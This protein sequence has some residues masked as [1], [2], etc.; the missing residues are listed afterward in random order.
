MTR[1]IFVRVG[2]IFLIIVAA[3]FVARYFIMQ[4]LSCVPVCISVNL[5]G[6]DMRGIDLS[7]VN[8]TEANLRSSDFTGANLRGS[9]FSGAKLSNAVLTKANLRG[10]A[11]IGAD[12]RGADLRGAILNGADLSGAVLDGADLTQLD[13][14]ET[15]LGGVSLAGAKLVEANLSGVNLPGIN[16][17]NADLNGANLTK[18]NLSGTSLSRANLS[19]AILVGTDIA[20]SWINLANLTGADLSGADLSGSSLIGTNLASARLA[21][22]RL[23][24]ANLVGAFFLGTDLRSASLQGIRLVVSEMQTQDYTDPE[25]ANLNELQRRT[26]IVDANLRGVQYNSQTQWPSG[27]L[28]LLAGLLGQEFAEAVAAQQVAEPTPEPTPVPEEEATAA[29]V[30]IVGQPQEETPDISFA[31]SG[32]GAPVTK[33]LYALF[34]SQ[35]YTNT[36]GFRDV[37]TNNAIALLCTSAEVDAILL[38]RRL[39]ASE[40][41]ACTTA[42]H[43]LI[44]LEVGAAVLVFIVDPT[45]AF[46]TDITTAEIPLLL[47]AEKWVQVRP[48]WPDAPIMRFL[49]S[50]G[51]GALSLLKERFF[52]ESETDPLATAP[53]TIFNPN[54]IQLVQAIATTPNS[55]G[56]FSLDNF[57]QNAEI[58][59]LV[60]VDGVTPNTTTVTSGVYSLTQPLMF[61][62]DLARVE[63]KPEAGY[64]LWF[65]LDTI[66]TLLERAGFVLARPEVMDLNRESLSPIP[67]LPS[68]PAAEDTTGEA[69]PTPEVGGPESTPT[70]E[71]QREGGGS[72]AVLPTPTI[73]ASSEITATILARLTATATAFV[74][75]PL[76]A[77]TPTAP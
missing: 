7:K 51:S 64:F 26:L 75:P 74:T 58:L 3:V 40:L 12:L 11:L 18:A 67:A 56:F 14:T 68:I 62:G 47:T 34:Q 65:Y 24:G 42:D 2:V 28:V 10:A 57:T 61:Y 45:N 60:A 59:K 8:F 37:E 41:D 30:D 31:L 29:P 32:P 48:D 55:L 13:L 39:T 25:L 35:G 6:R 69:T 16:F 72:V 15:R 1:F 43:E 44:S 71:A 52:A 20:G 22:A 5:I 49:T 66:N 53:N 21:G 17:V 38:A 70:P 19:G 54:E 23:I 63:E 33:N 73:R 27:K 77:A 9:D 4:S 46:L 36:I 76:P 50:E